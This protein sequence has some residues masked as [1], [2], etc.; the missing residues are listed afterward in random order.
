MTNPREIFDLAEKLYTHAKG[1]EAAFRSA[2]SRAY[3][4]IYHLMG[5]TLGLENYW[6]QPGSHRLVEEEIL[7]QTIA[8][9]EFVK[10]A[11]GTFKSLLD[12]R[13][14]ADYRLNQPF[15]NTDVIASMIRARQIFEAIDS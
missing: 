13:V 3:Y 7:S 12:A 1:N 10:L 8:C 11:K 4:S 15:T 6:Q 2:A 14:H 9:D 5:E